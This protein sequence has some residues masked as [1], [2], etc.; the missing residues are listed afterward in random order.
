L[1]IS[2]TTAMDTPTCVAPS[3]R[4]NS[5]HM[6]RITRATAAGGKKKKNKASPFTPATSS[7]PSAVAHSPVAD[8]DDDDDFAMPSSQMPSKRKD[9]EVYWSYESSPQ[10]RAARNKKMQAADDKSPAVVRAKAR[11]YTRLNIAR[12][13]NRETEGDDRG[14]EALEDMEALYHRM[15]GHKSVSPKSTNAPSPKTPSPRAHSP[16]ASC[17]SVPETPAN[18]FDN[19]K[20]DEDD[21]F[22]DSEDDSFLMKAT[23]A[24]EEPPVMKPPPAPRAPAPAAIGF[25]CTS[26][27]ASETVKSVA[28]SNNDD[29]PFGDDDDDSFDMLLSQID[30]TNLKQRTNSLIKSSKTAKTSPKMLQTPPVQPKFA[31]RSLSAQEN[32]ST[33]PPPQRPSFPR[34]ATSPDAARPVGLPGGRPL[35]RCTQ[36]QIRTKK[37]EAMKRRDMQKRKMNKQ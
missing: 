16:K 35:S 3:S 5:R 25:K 9:G 7:T 13:A 4:S 15:M 30:V 2:K 6:S 32:L 31:R 22:G 14:R 23:Q 34:C 37:I 19:C 33:P 20:E 36:D 11:A 8:I 1:F 28:A 24:V 29:D 17:H 21:P 26:N 12:A 18:L 27:V 10:T